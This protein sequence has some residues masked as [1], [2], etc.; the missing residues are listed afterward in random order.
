MNKL[1]R[2]SLRL[3]KLTKSIIGIKLELIKGSYKTIDR[4]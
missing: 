2:K 1:N 3:R 4:M